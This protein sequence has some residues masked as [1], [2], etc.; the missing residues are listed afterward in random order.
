[1][2]KT[3]DDATAEAVKRV[4]IDRDALV[5]EQLSKCPKLDPDDAL[6]QIH[7]SKINLYF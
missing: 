7:T 1:M 3:L 6:V 4:E 2:K 5:A